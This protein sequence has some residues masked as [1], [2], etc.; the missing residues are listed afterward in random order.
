MARSLDLKVIGEGVETN[1]QLEILK[2]EKCDTIQGY[3]YS[4]PLTPEDF[5][6]FLDDATET[7]KQA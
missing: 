1:E 7:R 5:K 2:A 3:Y 4:K 6:A